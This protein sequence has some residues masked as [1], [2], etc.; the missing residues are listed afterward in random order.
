M[1]KLRTFIALDMPS[2][3]KAALVTYVQPLKSL[4]GR[5]S[6]VKPENLHLTLKFLGDTPASQVEAIAVTLQDIAATATSFNVNIAGCGAFPHDRAPRVLWVGIQ[7]A[8][9]TQYLCAST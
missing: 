8:S 4:R 9:G 2:D 5:V 7:D 6:W 1:E 3:I